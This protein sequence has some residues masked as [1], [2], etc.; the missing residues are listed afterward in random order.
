MPPGRHPLDTTLGE[1]CGDP[2]CPYRSFELPLHPNR[3]AL[4]R[5]YA[6]SALRNAT[7][8][9]LIAEAALTRSVYRIRS[10][11]PVLTG[12]L[13]THPLNYR[14]PVTFAQLRR[15]PSSALCWEVVRIV[16]D[17]HGTSALCLP[18]GEALT[19][20]L[21]VHADEAARLEVTQLGTLEQSLPVL[22]AG[23]LDE[24][25]ATRLLLRLLRAGRRGGDR[26]NEPTIT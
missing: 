6:M 25:A 11:E 14:I 18:P 21:L 9:E 19:T 4:L 16:H 22:S 7:P 3:D 2:S 17:V 23:L 26:G 20:D 10:R 5:S 8:F 24:S 13:S 12:D 1:E 15:E